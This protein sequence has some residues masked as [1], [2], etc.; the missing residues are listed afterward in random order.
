MIKK[1]LFFIIFS[2]LLSPS[3]VKGFSSNGLNL[4]ITNEFQ[5][6][7]N[8]ISEE[9]N[10]FYEALSI[11]SGFKK[12]SANFTLR[13]NNYFRQ[14]PNKTLNSFNFDIFRKSVH[15][16]SKRISVTFGD[17]YSLLGR[18]LVLSVLKNDDILR[19]RTI[20][21]GNSDISF[22]NFDLK[23]LGGIIKDE[24]NLQKWNLAGGEFMYNFIKNNRA[25]LHFSY[26][27]DIDTLRNLGKRFTY[28]LSF[29]GTRIFKYFSYYVE[30]SY[31]DFIENSAKR[32]KAVYSNITF[33][34]GHLTLSAEYKFYKNFNNEMNNPPIA[35]REDEISTLSDSEGARLFVSYTIFDPDISLFFNIGSYR[36][37]NDSGT[38][39]FAGINSQDIWDKLSFT[40]SYGIKNILFPIRKFSSDI[41]FQ[42][43]DKFSMEFSSKDKS[44]RDGSFRFIE[45]DHSVQFSIYPFLSVTCLYQYSHNAVMGLHNFFSSSV[46]L[47]FKNNLEIAVSGGN[48]RGGQVCS[49]GQCFMMPPFKGIKF[50]VL[51]TIK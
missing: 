19:E 14:S 26:I 23:I 43:S 11:F 49:G 18:G 39:I 33:N 40:I 36:E 12:W 48:I 16:K 27:N 37:Y 17:F 8:K 44:Y 24:T 31:L 25:G 3:F 34:K 13:S 21:G 9:S 51:K 4:Y 50:S 1:T 38:H 42:F 20:L 28:S 7:F 2:F 15:F 5:Y 41:I 32:G 10:Q 22:K 47:F 35:D 30:T 46:T 29:Q 6:N 45:K